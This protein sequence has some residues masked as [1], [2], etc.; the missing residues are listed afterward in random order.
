[1]PSRSAASAS[2]TDALRSTAAD[3]ASCQGFAVTDCAA[4]ER[5]DRSPRASRNSPPWR[6]SPAPL[7]RLG[8]S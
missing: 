4:H 2:L 8:A 6:P 7:R 3:I 1:M 5:G